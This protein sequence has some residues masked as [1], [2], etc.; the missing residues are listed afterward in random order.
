[1]RPLFSP[2][3]FSPP[4]F[5]HAIGPAPKAIGLTEITFQTGRATLPWPG[6]V[7]RPRRALAMQL[8]IGETRG[9]GI[10][11]YVLSFKRIAFAGLTGFSGGAGSE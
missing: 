8:Q 3:V 5:L 10:D 7:L 9:T 1:M 2:L 4:F 11:K 6:S